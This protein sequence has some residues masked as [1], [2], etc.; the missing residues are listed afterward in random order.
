MA[1]GR[2]WPDGMRFKS[3][4]AY[5]GCCPT[6]GKRCGAEDLDAGPGAM[7]AGLDRDDM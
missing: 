4:G 7:R 1:I 2:R 3:Q 6:L 5:G